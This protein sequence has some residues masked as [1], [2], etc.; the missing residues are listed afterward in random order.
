VL[1]TSPDGARVSVERYFEMVECGILSPDDRVELLDGLIVSMAAQSAPHA[2]TVYRVQ[3][4]L[5]QKLG[6][7]TVVR[8]HS[9]FFAGRNSV[10]EPDIA[11]LPGR[12]D[13]YLSEPPS[14]AHLLVEVA[15]S[16]LIQDRLTKSA[17]YARAGVPCYWIVNLRDHCV[18]VFREP[19]RFRAAYASVTRATGDD[20]FS[21]D[22]F[23]EVEFTA[24]DLLPPWPVPPGI[25]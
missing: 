7:D 14:S 19:D 2:G 3:R 24:S 6:I 9:S 21:I 15:A 10:P 22:A 5:L 18:E 17:I 20:A 4:I 25:D 23:P 11:V 8:A 1:E 13:D 12:A 16:S